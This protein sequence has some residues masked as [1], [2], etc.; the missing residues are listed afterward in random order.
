MDTKLDMDAK[1]GQ[2]TTSAT[3]RWAIN[4]PLPTNNMHKTV[5]HKTR[6][7]S[8]GRTITSCLESAMIGHFFIFIP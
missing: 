4:P 5:V 2:T 1:L 7:H 3:D 6:F 8:I